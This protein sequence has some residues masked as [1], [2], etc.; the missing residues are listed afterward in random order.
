MAKVRDANAQIALVGMMGCGKTT[1]GKLLSEALDKPFCDL[2]EVIQQR[3]NQ[4]VNEFFQQ[5]GEFEFRACE[6]QVLRDVPRSHAG[7]ILATGGG[8]PLYYDNMAFLNANYLTIYLEIDAEHLVARLD[9]QRDTRP[10]LNRDDWQ[11]FLAELV[12]QR[13]PVYERADATVEVTGGDSEAAA[14][15]IVEALPQLTGH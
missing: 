6:A 13:G 14:R 1:V 4:T 5:H 3:T 10:L 8:T 9:K 12:E 7:A 2:D 15:N 11:D